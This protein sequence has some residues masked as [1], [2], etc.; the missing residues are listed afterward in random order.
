MGKTITVQLASILAVIQCALWRWTAPPATRINHQHRVVSRWQRPLC[1]GPN[2]QFRHHRATTCR[3]MEAALKAVLAQL[4]AAQRANV[5][6]VA[7]TAPALRQ[8]RLTPTVT[9]RRCV[10]V[11]REP[12]CD[13]CACGKITAVEEIGEITRLLYKRARSTTPLYWRHL[14]QRMVLG[15]DSARHPGRIAPRAEPPSWIELC[16]WVPALLSAH[17]SRRISAVA[18]AA[19]GAKRCG[20]KAGAVCRPRKLTMNSIVH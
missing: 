16:D 10:R 8:R 2:N 13:V 12:E 19:P 11:R 14:L 6:R 1:D 7:L 15:E 5:E 9:S 4:S 3:S 17:H 20:M 18:A